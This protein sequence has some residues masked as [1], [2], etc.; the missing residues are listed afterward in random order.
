MTSI[1]KFSTLDVNRL[2]YV[3]GK[4]SGG[5]LKFN[6]KRVP[7]MQ[8]DAHV[9]FTHDDPS[10][11][12]VVR[13]PVREMDILR[14]LDKH[15]AANVDVYGRHHKTVVSKAGYDDTARLTL[16]KNCVVVGPESSQLEAGS[17]VRLLMSLSGF[18]RS[19][20]IGSGLYMRIV[21]LQAIEAPPAAEIPDFMSDDE[22]EPCRAKGDTW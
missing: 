5:Y 8:F 2:D 4:S 20:Q 9:V 7:Y 1:I 14:N 13:A 11:K 12:L 10:R 6:G 17:K 15:F 19:E 16:D 21:R 3:D 22:E 18:Y